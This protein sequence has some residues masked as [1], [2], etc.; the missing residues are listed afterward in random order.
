MHRWS[1]RPSFTFTHPQVSKARRDALGNP[2]E[3]SGTREGAPSADAMEM[4]DHDAAGG[5]SGG[6]GGEGR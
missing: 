1:P 4:D 2:I 5:G 6:K 3:E